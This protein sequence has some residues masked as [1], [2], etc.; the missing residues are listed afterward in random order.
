MS[1]NYLPVHSAYGRKDTNEQEVLESWNSEL[2][3]K[4]V[5]GPYISKRDVDALKK[6]L[7]IGIVVINANNDFI[8]MDFD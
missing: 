6:E 4:I 1:F 7:Y 3:F 2:D 5:G 8:Y